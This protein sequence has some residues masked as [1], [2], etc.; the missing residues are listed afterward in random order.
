M[1]LMES[2]WPVVTQLEQEMRM[3]PEA[4]LTENPVTGV[5]RQHKVGELEAQK[6]AN[7]RPRCSVSQPFNS[8]RFGHQIQLRLQSQTTLPLTAIY[9]PGFH[10]P[11]DAQKRQI[12]L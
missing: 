7:R 6:V 4:G 1:P 5:G 10:D 9:A 12:H 11:R 2:N 3:V 8:S